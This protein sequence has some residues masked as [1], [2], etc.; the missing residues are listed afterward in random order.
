ML[1]GKLSDDKNFVTRTAF[2]LV[3]AVVATLALTAF[4]ANVNAATFVVNTTADTQDANTGDGLCADSGGQCSLRAAISQAN[5]LAGADIITLPAGTYTQTLVAANEDA[6]AGG[7]WDISSPITINGA[8]AATTIIQANAAQ[9]TATERVMHCILGSTAV[10][11][12]N[13][14]LRHG[15]NKY[16]TVNPGGGGIVLDG[17]TSDLTLNNVIVTKNTSEGRAGGVRVSTNN[18]KLTITNSTISENKS[19]SAVVG[20]GAAGGGIDIS[21]TAGS[22]TAGTT[23]VNITN[24]TV[25]GNTVN[26]SALST[27]GTGTSAFGG[28]II[29]TSIA[30]TINITGC[31]FSNNSVTSTSVGSSNG[32]GNGGGIY[33]QSANVNITNTAITG[34]SSSHFVGGLRILSQFATTTNVTNSTISNN[35]AASFYGGIFNVVVAGFPSDLTIVGSTISNN[36]VTG[37]N[38]QGGGIANTNSGAA[39]TGAATVLLTN[40]TVSGNVANDLAGIF[41]TGSNATF[42]ANF[43]TISGN[44]ANNTV[45]PEGGGVFQDATPGGSSFLQNT[46]VA[47]NVAAIGPDIDGEIFSLDYNLIEDPA[48][49]TFV[50]AAH[51]E[52]GVDPLLGALANNGGPTQTLLPG[53]GSVLIDKIPNGT[54]DCGSTINTDQRGSVRPFGG[55]CDKG[56]VEV[57]AGGTPTPTNTPTATPTNTPTATPTNTPTAT[58]TNTPT[59][60][61]TSTPTSTPT[62]SPLKS[63]ADFDADGKTDLSV[64][65]PSDGTW[66]INRSRDGFIQR[67]FGIAGDTPIPGDYDNDGKT[68]IAIFRPNADNVTPDFFVLNSSTSTLT[69]AIWGNPGDTA[70]AGDFDGDGKADFTVFRPSDNN[71]YILKS[72]GGFTL[73]QFGATG[74]TPMGMDYDGDGKTNLAV[75]RPT[76]NTW[77][78]AKATGVPAQSFDAVAFGATGDMPAPADYDGDGKDDIAVFRPSTGTWWLLRSTAGLTAVQF[79]ASGDVPVP[80]DYDGDGTD[81]IGVFRAGTWFVNRSTA[82]L[83]QQ[84]FGTA[85]DTPIPKKYIP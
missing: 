19:G 16:T 61:P 10:V 31:T 75:F 23:L 21:Q 64:F 13:V 56:S 53:A 15:V 47:N 35:T 40:S 78:I 79:G 30:A 69:T 48:D 81:D 68:D 83:L 11:I 12:N 28:G 34:N 49:G 27:T 29:I 67:A 17:A 46:V 76:T 25:T 59:A 66:Y 14:T 52:T 9:D 80:G 1:N 50:T 65:R 37:V 18:A 4:S 5:A 41:N 60:T 70:I 58:P 26:T 20:S 24:T 3:F 39:G 63:R 6:N 33:N 7:D 54:N 73:S 77:Y 85:T 55:T 8:T 38:G 71:W 84:T 42:F 36:T 44:T 43:S 51:D 57:G 32:S 22:T 2:T 72:T 62:P 82:G 45:N 74:D